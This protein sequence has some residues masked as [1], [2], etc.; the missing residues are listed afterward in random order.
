M[1]CMRNVTLTAFAPLLLFAACGD[2]DSSPGG[3][4]AAQQRGVGDACAVDADCVEAGQKCLTSFKGGYC[5]IEG[6]M[7][8]ADCPAGSRCVRE[9]GSTFCFLICATKDQCNAY[10]PA[11]AEA[12]C[13][14]SVT[15]TEADKGDKACVPPS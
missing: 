3:G 6:C 11:S 9:G 1:T 4:S 10:R 8:S 13:S 15:F 5:G 12:N 7:A 14:S 2:G